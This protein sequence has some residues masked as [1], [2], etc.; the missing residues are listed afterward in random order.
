MA[1]WRNISFGGLVFV[2]GTTA[3]IMLKAEHEH[4]DREKNAFSYM[5]VRAKDYPWKCGDCNLFDTAW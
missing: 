3:Y 1:L 5:H 4:F 2:G